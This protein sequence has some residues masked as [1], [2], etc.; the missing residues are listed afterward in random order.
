MKITFLGTSSGTPSRH[1][2]VSSLALQLPQQGTLWLFDCGEGTQH[3]V[4][5]S[6]LR[7][8]QLERVFITHLHGDHLFGL[9]GLLATRSL[10]AGGVSPVTLYGP[11]GL[12]EYVRRVM[13]LSQMRV[14]YP[15]EVKTITPGAIYEDA[16]F[17]VVCAPVM[18]RITAFGYAVIEKD[19][20]GRFEVE[21]AQALGIP[22]GPLYGRLK[23]G[24]TITLE[25]GRVIDGR[26]LTGPMRPGRKIVYTGDTTYTPQTVTLAQNA[27]VLIHEAT[28]LEED[29]D[30]AK[31]AAHSTAKM[32]AQ[33][34]G[35]AGVKTLILTH[36]SSRYEM[37]AGSRLSDLLEEARSIFPNTL[38]AY[39]FYSYEVDRTE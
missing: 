9:V 28:Y 30:L 32:A 12:A 13:D 8:S 16:N 29:L 27:D 24:E 14:G 15:I 22:A 11:P 23:N 20:P 7:L 26:E 19:Q 2:N 36:F 3:Q 35:E 6:P 21:K 18:H 5:R 34:A 31:R 37:D 10:Q 25:D 1:R 33:V 4:L 39:D 17:S 38:L